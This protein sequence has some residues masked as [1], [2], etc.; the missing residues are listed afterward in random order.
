MGRNNRFFIIKNGKEVIIVAWKTL[1]SKIKIIE[2][3]FNLD[4]KDF[5]QLQNIS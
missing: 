1:V 4:F 3:N 5:I 2:A